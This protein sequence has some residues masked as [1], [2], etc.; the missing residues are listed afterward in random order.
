MVG[1]PI[2]FVRLGHADDGTSAG[3]VATGGGGPARAAGASLVGRLRCGVP[4]LRWQLAMLEQAGH[5]EQ[6]AQAHGGIVVEIK[7]GRQ[8]LL[9]FQARA[10]LLE[11]ARAFRG[12]ARRFQ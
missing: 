3:I 1:H 6:Y 7:L 8:V 12:G 11:D 4:E 9:L 2:A 10:E 5:H